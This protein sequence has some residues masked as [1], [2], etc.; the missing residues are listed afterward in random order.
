MIHSN[1]KLQEGR[2]GP[3]RTRRTIV[4]TVARS[5][6]RESVNM[7]LSKLMDA[8]MR[9]T[10][11]RVRHAQYSRPRPRTQRGGPR[12]GL[13]RAHRT[14]V[15]REMIARPALRVGHALRSQVRV[16][17]LDRSVVAAQIVEHTLAVDTET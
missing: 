6:K 16:D 11:R 3:R 8:S 1:A 7:F 4:L 9:I 14:A 12:N 17:S 5:T 2:A 10:S 13:M 15:I